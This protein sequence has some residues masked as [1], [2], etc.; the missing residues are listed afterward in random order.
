MTRAYC[1]KVFLFL[2]TTCILLREHI[3]K[4]REGVGETFN[5]QRIIDGT[6]FKCLF[7]RKQFTC[8]Y[9]SMNL[10]REITNSTYV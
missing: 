10:N 3:V 5:I 8:L 4:L 1:P 9:V 2:L 6:K 7:G